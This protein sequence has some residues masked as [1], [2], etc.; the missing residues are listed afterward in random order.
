MFQNVKYGNQGSHIVSTCQVALGLRIQAMRHAWLNLHS[1]MSWQGFHR[2]TTQ[3]IFYHRSNALKTWVI[4]L[5]AVLLPFTLLLLYAS[6]CASCDGIELCYPWIL[7]H[8]I[9]IFDLDTAWGSHGFLF[10]AVGLLDIPIL[11]YLHDCDE[12]DIYTIVMNEINFKGQLAKYSKLLKSRIGLV[13]DRSTVHSM[14]NYEEL[15]LLG[16]TSIPWPCLF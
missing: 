8:P 16:C 12:W 11:Y 6:C 13:N 7:N 15:Y 9:P 4:L 3:N 5:S 2:N 1:T 10:S 14:Q